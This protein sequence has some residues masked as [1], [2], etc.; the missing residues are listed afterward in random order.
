MGVIVVEN[1][2]IECLKLSMESTKHLSASETIARA[3]EYE[4]YIRSTAETLGNPV[5]GQ[6]DSQ[7]DGIKHSKKQA[8]K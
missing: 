2:R 4:N 1:I 8:P 5:M 3:K 7:K 6:D